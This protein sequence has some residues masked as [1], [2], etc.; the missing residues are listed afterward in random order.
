MT[1]LMGIAGG[2]GSGKTTIAKKISSSFKNKGNV[3]IIEMDSYYKNVDFLPF[4]ERE[5]I[6]YDHPDA[7]DFELL[8]H[9]LKMLSNGKSIKKPVYD[10]CKSC[11]FTKN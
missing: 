9:H 7:M 4:S 8:K 2:S 10:F 6:N 1:L 11:S 3:T 5:K